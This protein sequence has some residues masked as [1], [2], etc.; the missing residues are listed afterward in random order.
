MMHRIAAVLVTASVVCVT[1]NAADAAGLPAI[2]ASDRNAVPACVTPGRLISFL[3]ARN[4]GLDPRFDSVPVAYMRY[5][6]ELNLRWDYAFFQMMLETG[7]LAFRRGN[8]KPGDVKPTQNNFAGLGATGGGEPGESFASVDAGVK[9]HLQHVLMYSGAHVDNPVAERTRK[10][11]EWGVLTSWQQGFS[12][13]ITYADLAKKWAP[14]SRGYVSDIQSISDAFFTEFCNRP[15]P[16]P[17]LVQEARTGI[18]AASATKVAAAAPLPP[19]YELKQPITD[20]SA[21]SFQ[22]EVKVEPSKPAPAVALAP[23]T[24]TV[25]AEA[26]PATAEAVPAAA[27]PVATAAQPGEPDKPTGAD[28]VRQAMERGKAEGATL[29]GLGAGA[30]ARPPLELPSE[31]T[32]SNPLTK[33]LAFLSPSTAATTSPAP[34][35]EAV[36]PEAKVEVAVVQKPAFEALPQVPEKAPQKSQEA[37]ARSV[38][39]LNKDTSVAA[40]TG[41]GKPVEKS[42]TAKAEK[43]A[44]SVQLAAAGPG[45]K[46]ATVQKAPAKSAEKQPSKCRVFT[47]SYGGQKSIIIKAPDDAFVNYTVLDVNEGTEEREA[48]A[49]IAAYAKGGQRVGEFASQATALDKAFELCPEG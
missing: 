12:N 29:S 22:A 17:A 20:A 45:A 40:K 28:L 2:K 24:T 9:A 31:G 7:N 42:E 41:D 5:G 25:A 34:A 38:E 37:S 14:G 36:Q 1:V 8:G 13:P 32:S 23:T 16:A 48:A 35:Q 15:D 46:S 3:K 10:V 33:L 21:L 43:P 30:I 18:G 6:E 44:A 19:K 47:A 26:A 4:P 49:Y 27:D 39:I 11:Q